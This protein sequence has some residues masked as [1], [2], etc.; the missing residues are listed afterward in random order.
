MVKD[1]DLTNTPEVEATDTGG[2]LF[3]I[4]RIFWGMFLALLVLDISSTGW[5]HVG[6]DFF[7]GP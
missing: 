1:N 5:L 4:F 7:L 6:V 3:R 2:K